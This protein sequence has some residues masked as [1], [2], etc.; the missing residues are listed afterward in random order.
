MTTC[1]LLRGLTREAGHWGHFP[2]ELRAALGDATVVAIDLPGA[3]ALHAQRSPANI[4]DIATQCRAQ[5]HALG[6]QAP[7]HLVALSLGAMVAVAWATRHPEEIA[8][9]VLINTSLGSHCPPWHRL[10]PRN[11]PAL[12]R[13]LLP[14]TDATRE[15]IIYRLTSNRPDDEEATVIAWTALRQEH[16]VAAANAFR[17]L[18]A[19]ARYRPPA[20]PDRT[21][22]LVLASRGDHLVDPDCSRRLAAAWQADYAKHPNAGHDLPLDDGPWVAARIADWLANR[23]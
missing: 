17:Q 5:A 16:P 21:R 3:G 13:L 22:L 2:E 9:A 1:I 10:K 7:Y 15:S 19:A 8:A 14:A 6:L 23:R 11:Y 4:E 18:W 12:L 20:P